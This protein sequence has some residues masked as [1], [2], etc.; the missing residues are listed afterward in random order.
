MTSRV[1][2]FD[3]PIDDAG[4]AGAFYRT[5]FGWNVEKWGPIDYWTMTTGEPAGPGG[6]EC[7]RA[8]GRGRARTWATPVRSARGYLS[9]MSRERP[10]IR[11][12]SASTSASVWYR[13][14]GP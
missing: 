14:P 12:I 2:H 9:L 10:V 7:A 6:R 3:I 8:A 1:V 13:R 5:V 11:S 4:R